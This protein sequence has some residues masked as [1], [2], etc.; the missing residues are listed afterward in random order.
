MPELDAVIVGSGPN[1]LAAGVVLARAGLRVRLYEAASTLGGGAR[2]AELTLPGFL[3]DVCS[4]VHPMA[5]ASPF[6]RAF[7]LDRRI[8]LLLPEVSYGHPLDGGIAGLAHRDIDS[9]IA[10]LAADGRAWRDLIGALAAHAQQLAEISGTSLARF[11][12][13]PLVLASLGFRALEQG[14]NGWNRRFG[15]DVAPGMLS[16]VFAHTNR[17]LPDVGAASA[18]LVL[19]A[20]A[21]AAG[22]PIPV[23]GSQSIV[24]A[25]L[26]DFTAHG[27]E[28]V[29]GTRIT[30]LAELPSATAVLLDV[31][32]RSLVAM[33]G[34]RMPRGAATRLGRFRYGNAVAKVDYAL[35]GP[36]PWAA[37]GLDQ[38]GTVH[39]G[40]TRAQIVASE[41]AVGDGRLP[42]APYVLVAQPSVI[43]ESRAPSGKHVLWAYT[44]VPPG[45]T[46]DR[47]EAI[48][49]QIERFAPGFRDLILESVPSTAIQTEAHNANYVGGDISA[50]DTSLWQLLRRP[51]L[52][53]PWSTPIDGVYLCSASTAPG[54]GVHG[55]G[56]YNAARLVLAR[57]F[58]MRELP[59]LA[60]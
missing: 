30:D 45:S 52:F 33:A 18:G 51:T 40:G 9:T 32:P 17:A 54:P 8:E 24:G 25:M 55:M 29:T 34:D 57:E 16:G 4:A 7:G 1:G 58:G 38:A 3:H 26:A 44:H 19:A 60:P 28:A 13:H 31:T 14:G 21:H 39:L 41:R 48:T 11:P 42:E 12:R 46:A 36:V 22:W 27:G 6:F 47:S 37:E 43:D 59:S 50:G 20:H 49:A 10:E 53:T 35:D 15:G 2:T 23:G 5:L 56:G